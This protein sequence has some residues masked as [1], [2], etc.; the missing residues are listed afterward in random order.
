MQHLITL[1]K[2]L[3]WSSF[4][5]FFALAFLIIT[6]SVTKH[7]ATWGM[8]TILVLASFCVVVFEVETHQKRRD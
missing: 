1:S 3:I 4:V 7:Q 6:E 5:G 2:G 8:L